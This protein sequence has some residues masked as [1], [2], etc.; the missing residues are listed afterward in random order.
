[1][2]KAILSLMLASGVLILFCTCNKEDDK[3]VESGSFSDPRDGQT[4][5]W[6]KIGNQ[7]WM[8]ENLN[9]VADDSWCHNN[10]IANCGQ[11]G[12]MYTWDAVMNGA[13]SSNAT[14]SGV[15]GVCPAGWHVPSDAEWA[16]L[17]N[18]VGSSSA[19]KLKAK[20]GWSSDG[21]GTDDFGFSALPGSIRSDNGIFS[22][23]GNY[24]YWWSSTENSSSHVLSWGMASS[25]VDVDR[26]NI[27][28]TSGFSLR[29]VQD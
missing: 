1:M 24:G 23:I 4:Y 17:I 11:Y 19:T 14:P 5:K 3:K 10:I 6:V 21:N 20:N 29:C 7:V 18:Y 26:L 12:R 9:L 8:A 16:Q 25:Y 22:G 13:S 27:S 28:K 15:Q 2:K